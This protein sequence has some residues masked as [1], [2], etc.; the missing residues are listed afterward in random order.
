MNSRY[1]KVKQHLINGIRDNRWP[2]GERI[3]SENE[4]VS[5]CKVSRMTARRAIK[6][7]E[8]EGVLFSVRGKG[9]F[10]T[11]AKSHSSAIELRNIAEE[12][13][14]RNNTYRC[15][16]LQHRVVSN[17]IICALFGPDLDKV[18]FSSVIHYENDL[19]IQVEERYVHPF[20][21]DDYLSLDLKRITANEYLTSKCPVN[22]VDHQIE[23]VNADSQMKAWLQ[24]NDQ[25]PCLKVSRMTRYQDSL[26]SYAKLYHPGSRFVLG[27]QF[28]IPASELVN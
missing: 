5:E 1:Q 28:A 16:V 25:E 12:I 20:Y 24:L 19:P 18:Y 13:R 11:P 22:T 9:T 17:P 15:D 14:N 26:I 4:L 8:H 21:A 2:E 7:L 27:T 3:V 23:A 6:E 10:I